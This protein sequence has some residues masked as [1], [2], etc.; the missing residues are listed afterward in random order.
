MKRQAM[1]SALFIAV[2]L[3]SSFGSVMYVESAA[4]GPVVPCDV[5]WNKALNQV[6]DKDRRKY[7]GCLI[8]RLPRPRN[9]ANVVSGLIPDI[10]G[11]ITFSDL[12]SRAQTASLTTGL[13]LGE[14]SDYVKESKRRSTIACMEKL[15]VRGW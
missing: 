2:L 15:V 10:S 5:K 13:S 7:L 11:C 3:C 14:I 12:D 4:A 1:F 8:Y 6:K 9:Y